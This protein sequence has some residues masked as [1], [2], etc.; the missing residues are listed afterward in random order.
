MACSVQLTLD[1]SHT[2]PENMPAGGLVVVLAA[3]AMVP[4]TTWS[5]LE[6]PASNQIPDGAVVLGFP[7][8]RGAFGSVH[9]ASLDGKRVIAK[10][11][12]RN[13]PNAD[14]YL[15]AEAAINAK[16]GALHPASCHLAPFVGVCSVGWVNHLVWQA[17]PGV[18]QSLEAYLNGG[19][20]RE[21]ARDLGL[22]PST[23][24]DSFDVQHL[25]SALLAE[26]LSALAM[27]HRDGIVH[28]DIKPANWVVD[29]H[30]R[31]LRLIDF[32]AA[33]D[34]STVTAGQTLITP[35][36]TAYA[37]P[38]LRLIH[39]RPWAYDVYSV[40]LVWLRVVSAS[41][42]D[43][44][45]LCTKLRTQGQRI[46]RTLTAGTSLLSSKAVD[47]VLPRLLDVDPYS[48]MSAAE[49]LGSS[50]YETNKPTADLTDGSGC[51]EDFSCRLD[52]DTAVDG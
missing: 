46:E 52:W 43:F 12:A 25:G 10:R 45:A 29:T 47:D 14:A 2:A 19:R 3:S 44:D 30:T 42:R 17:C 16:V 1:R 11:A 13:R 34:T 36:T 4:S 5:P 26:M 35:A 31:S 27:V 6:L 23:S 28:R 15:H 38:E 24:S 8:A 21:L 48:R 32:G 51:E 20:L 40:A 7:L 33:I 9:W 49:A 37:P 41:S 50:F 22:I 18:Q 39:D